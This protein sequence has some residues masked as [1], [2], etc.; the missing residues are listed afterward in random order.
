MTHAR[1]GT[2]ALLLR[3]VSDGPIQDEG[4]GRALAMD[5]NYM[6]VGASGATT[7]T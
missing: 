2:Y 6:L 3:S 7:G 4:F 5:G 1:P